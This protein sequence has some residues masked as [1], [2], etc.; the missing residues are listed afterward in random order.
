MKSYLS[1]KL[2]LFRQILKKKS[3]IITDKEIKQFSVLKKISKKR[4]LKLLDISKDFENIKNDLY[5]YISDFKIKNIAM[6]IKATKLCGLKENLIYKTIKKIKNVNGRLEL[7]KS[8]S[9]D[10]K[11]F[12]D[13]AHTPDA[14]LKTLKSLRFFYKKNISLVFGCGGDRDQRKRPLMAKIANKYCKKIYVTDDNP[15]NENPE[16]IRKEL[17]KYINKNKCFNISNRSLAIK[18][19]IENADQQEIILI[20]GKGHEEFQVYKN[21]IINVSDKKI[22]RKNKIKNFK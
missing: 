18:K 17:S 3:T 8:Y 6:A 9:N 13:Y 10:V 20:A 22:V 5:E 12:I 21:R 14:L 2:I 1:A 16:K 4:N 11:V 7:V 19:A 15:R